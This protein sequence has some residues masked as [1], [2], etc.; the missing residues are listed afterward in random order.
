MNPTHA[1]KG[2]ILSNLGTPSAPTAAA[3]KTYLAEFLSD[4]LVVKI[5]RLIWKPLLHGVILRSRPPKSAAMYQKIWMDGGSPLLVHSLAQVAALQQRL[6]TDT[7]VTLG[8]R[9]GEPSIPSAIK[10]LQ[11]AGVT[12]LTVLPLY[13]QFSTST[14][15]STFAAL[16]R[17]LAEAH[18]KPTVHTL[19]QY[20]THPLYIK[21]LA[22]SIRDYWAQHPRGEKLVFSFHG[23]PEASVSRG[24]PYARQCH[25]T[26][27]AVAAALNLAP[28]EWVTV[29]QSRFGRAK[30]LQPYC[31]EVLKKL[32]SQGV[33]A[34]DVVCP[35][36]PS[37]CLETLEEMNMTNRNLFLES[38]GKQFNYI[39]ALNATP[40]HIDL[41][42]NLI[43]TI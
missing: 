3:V 1:K 36:F 2:V 9:Y 39:P 13:P 11:Q 18:F 38:G 28:T 32:P 12:E 26:A 16:E 40:A 5:P 22:E 17:G 23:I 41:F 34:V 30:W 37:D 25:A 10:T 21:A 43:T 7:L 33:T 31:V 27:A 8:M 15:C 24:D 4:P 35:G 42:A 19:T 29:F 14:S 6:G 20:A